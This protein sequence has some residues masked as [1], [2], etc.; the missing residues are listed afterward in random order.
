MARSMETGERPRRGRPK[1]TGIDD[2]AVL[3]RVSLLLRANVGLKPTTAIKQAGITDPSIVRRLRDKLKV[4]ATPEPAPAPA[5]PQPSRVA[6]KVR[7]KAKKTKAPDRLPADAASGTG[8]ASQPGTTA[9]A[10]LDH[11]PDHER[12]TIGYR[13]RVTRPAA[14]SQCRSQSERAHRQHAGRLP[15]GHGRRP[16]THHTAEQPISQPIR[17]STAAGV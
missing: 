10:A 11:H 14:S 16:A 6:G 17:T 5:E 8:P 1:G 4:D 15:G 2:T 7:P 9:I 12:D 13:R 3:Q